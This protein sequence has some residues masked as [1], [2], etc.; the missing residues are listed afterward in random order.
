MNNRTII[1]GVFVALCLIGMLVLPA[2]AVPAGQAAAV[3]GSAID[4]GLINDLWANHQQYRLQVFD[5]NVQRGT[6]VI[7]ILDKYGID[8]TACQATLST[9]SSKRSN[10]EAA[11]SARNREQLKTFNAELKTLWQQFLK[12]MRDAIRA[13]Y[14]TT[15]AGTAPS[16]ISGISDLASPGIGMA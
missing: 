15:A 10:L 8:S 6:S 2:A 9:I 5:M 3:K 14:K 1:K 16:G 4:Q 11:L 7:T 13:H 12:D